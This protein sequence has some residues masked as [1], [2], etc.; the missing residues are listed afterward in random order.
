MNEE[1]DMNVMPDSFGIALPDEWEEIPLEPQEYMRHVA[2]KAE[3]LR[4][5]GS[6]RRTDVRQYELLS[7]SIH[8]LMSRWRLI[9][10]SSFVSVVENDDG[11]PA[12]A[13]DSDAPQ[14]NDDAS[15]GDAM[16]VLAAN[17]AMS[18]LTREDCNSVLPLT[19]DLIVRSL[20]TDDISDPVNDGATVKSVN[21]E[22]PRVCE[23][24]GLAAVKLLRLV[25]IQASATDSF[26]MFSQSYML[27]VARGDAL[28][29][30]QMSTPNFTNARQFSELFTSIGESLRV[31]YPEDST[32]GVASTDVDAEVG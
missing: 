6:L 8:R 25:T 10:A 15:N 18:M 17:C 14:G 4:Q 20:G 19:A 11:T 31:M 30:L 1:T 5:R 7:A 29:L 27:P 13:D 32:F 24:G 16:N 22:P 21:V 12:L 9:M 26:K 23:I 3:E 28:V 2:R